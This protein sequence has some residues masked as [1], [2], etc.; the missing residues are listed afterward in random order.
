MII[1]GA[2]DCDVEEGW[3]A[4]V[5][6]CVDR[7]VEGYGSC[8]HFEFTKMSSFVEIYQSFDVCFL[9]VIV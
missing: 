2:D 6:H 3:V 8:S 9:F 1:G 7:T 5:G 4:G